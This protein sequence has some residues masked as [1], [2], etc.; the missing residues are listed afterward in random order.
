[1]KSHKTLQSLTT[2]VAVILTLA[3]V[4]ATGGAV[5]SGSGLQGVVIALAS[6]GAWEFWGQRRRIRR[7][8]RSRQQSSQ[9]EEDEP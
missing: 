3:A 9:Q 2:C 6:M 7:R 4:L 1:M 5:A 8:M